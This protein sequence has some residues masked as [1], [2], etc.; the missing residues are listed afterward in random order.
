M[1]ILKPE[2]MLTFTRVGCG[3]LVVYFACAVCLVLRL[4]FNLPLSHLIFPAVQH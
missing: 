4:T 2:A 3:V 1:H